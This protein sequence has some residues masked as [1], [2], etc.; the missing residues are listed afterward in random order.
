V[1]DFAAGAVRKLSVDLAASRESINAAKALETTG[2]TVWPHHD[3]DAQEE[4]RTPPYF[5]V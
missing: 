3:I 5:C 2:A 1:T 4:I